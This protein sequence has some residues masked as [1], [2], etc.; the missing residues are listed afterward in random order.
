[1][2]IALDVNSAANINFN[3]DGFTQL[4]LG[5]MGGAS[6]TYTGTLTPLSSGNYI[7]GNGGGTITFSNANAFTGANNLIVHPGA[8][9]GSISSVIADGGTS[10]AGGLIYS[11][12]GTLVLNAANTFRGGLNIT[13]TSGTVLLGNDTAL[14]INGQVNLNASGMTIAS[15]DASTRTIP[16]TTT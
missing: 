5:A 2:S 10:T 1:G 14:G 8:G 3:T 15:A 13:T 11:G 6:V 16:S 12:S 7:V 9:S 4:G